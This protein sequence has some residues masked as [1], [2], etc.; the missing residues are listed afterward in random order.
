V[1]LTAPQWRVSPLEALRR[2]GREVLDDNERLARLHFERAG[3]P[4]WSDW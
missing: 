2:D 3:K 1:P 4:G